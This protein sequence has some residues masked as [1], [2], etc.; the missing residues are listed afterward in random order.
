MLHDFV[1]RFQLP[2]GTDAGRIAWISGDNRFRPYRIS[3]IA[4]SLGLSPSRALE[5]IL[6]SRV[7]SWEN[8]VELLERKLPQLEDLKLIIIS[9]LTTM[10]P[11]HE[12]KTMGELLTMI[13]GI[14]KTFQN[15]N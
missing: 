9:G 5:N 1:V 12:K 13:A 4:A 15:L 10:I 7:F 6:I 8:M 14:K 3:K 2:T 11:D